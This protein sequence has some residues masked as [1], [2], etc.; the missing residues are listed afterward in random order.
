MPPSKS[1]PAPL[2]RKESGSERTGR[3][4]VRAQTYTHL[5]GAARLLVL[6]CLRELHVSD[7]QTLQGCRAGVKCS[8]ST[9]LHVAYFHT[10]A[11]FST[12]GNRKSNRS[13]FPFLY[14]IVFHLVLDI[15]RYYSI[16]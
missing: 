4:A 6:P 15:V 7:A 16:P 11:R 14:S 13:G 10:V 9:Q 12:R 2:R 1:L 5:R 3:K 8:T